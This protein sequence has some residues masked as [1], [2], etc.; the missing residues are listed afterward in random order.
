MVNIFD[1]STWKNVDAY[2]PYTVSLRQNAEPSKIKKFKP[3]IW[4]L[5]LKQ[6]RHNQL[7][8][9]NSCVVFMF[10][11]SLLLLKMSLL[12]P[13]NTEYLIVFI[14]TSNV[15]W[16]RTVCQV[17]FLVLGNNVFYTSPENDSYK[18]CG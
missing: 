1:L 17:L 11:R 8:A 6:E 16:A 7:A 3:S 2:V 18:I 10:H 4:Y 12:T 15:Y 14:Q 13:S 5:C 9:S